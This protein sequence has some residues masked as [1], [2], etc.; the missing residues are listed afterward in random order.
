MFAWAM[1]LVSVSLDFLAFWGG[2]GGVVFLTVFSKR[3]FQSAVLRGWQ[4]Y[5]VID[6]FPLPFVFILA[7]VLL[8]H[9]I[10]FTAKD[11]G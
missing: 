9:D 1:V 11:S 5:L 2:R 10:F 6:M 4:A 3:C 8:L 7:L